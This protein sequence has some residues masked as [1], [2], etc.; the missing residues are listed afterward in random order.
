MTFQYC[1]KHGLLDRSL[2]LL[3]ISV[4]HTS[5][6]KQKQCF[7]KSVLLCSSMPIYLVGIKE[8]KAI[9]RLQRGVVIWAPH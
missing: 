3:L 9:A 5:V 7:K 8:E 1:N 4:H 6:S 2:F